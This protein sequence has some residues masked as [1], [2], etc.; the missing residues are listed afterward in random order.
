MKTFLQKYMLVDAGRKLDVLCTFNLRPVSTGMLWVPLLEAIIL[1]F[2]R[3]IFSL[4]TLLE[5]QETSLA[6]KGDRKRRMA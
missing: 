5:H 4:Y 6:L 2:F 1:A 3:Y